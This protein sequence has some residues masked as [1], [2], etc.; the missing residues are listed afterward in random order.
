[1]VGCLENGQFNPSTTDTEK[2]RYLSSNLFSPVLSSPRSGVLKQP[3][4]SPIA[5]RFVPEF[6]FAAHF[7]WLKHP[8]G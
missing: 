3:A 7:F 5:R 1:M 2:I 8:I 6:G 4:W